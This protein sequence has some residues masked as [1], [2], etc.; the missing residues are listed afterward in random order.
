[1]GAEAATDLLELFHAFVLGSGGP[2][3][4]EGTIAFGVRAGDGRDLWWSA[5]FG[6]TVEAGFGA[7]RPRNADAVLHLGTREASAILDRGRLPECPELV[8]LDGEAALI[9]RFLE[10]YVDRKSALAIRS[11]EARATK[12]QRKRR[13]VR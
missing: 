8:E 11:G 3:G 13:V 5:R 9:E 12:K 10:R 7:E 6:P 2:P 1:M 4:F